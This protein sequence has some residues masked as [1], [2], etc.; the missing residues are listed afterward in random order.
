LSEWQT[1]L[2]TRRDVRYIQTKALGMLGLSSHNTR[3]CEQDVWR[4][5]A[6]TDEWLRDEFSSC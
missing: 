3:V 4:R 5:I 6:P 2:I 1:E